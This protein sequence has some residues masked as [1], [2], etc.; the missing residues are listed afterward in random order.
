MRNCFKF[1]EKKISVSEKKNSSLITK[2]D[3]GFDPTLVSCIILIKC[4]CKF[5]KNNHE[6]EILKMSMSFL[7][8]SGNHVST[9]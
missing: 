7:G 1:F 4:T 6:E 9:K 2:L 3:L 8:E 5:Q